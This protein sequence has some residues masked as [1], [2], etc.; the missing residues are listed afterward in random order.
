MSYDAILKLADFYE[1][2]ALVSYGKVWEWVDG[3]PIYSNR[4]Y[5]RA[6]LSQISYDLSSYNKLPFFPKVIIP[7]VPAPIPIS[8]TQKILYYANPLANPKEHVSLRVFEDKNFEKSN[9]DKK[10]IYKLY[11]NEIVYL[12][13]MLTALKQAYVNVSQFKGEQAEHFV[14]AFKP[15]IVAAEKSLRSYI[16]YRQGYM[17]AIK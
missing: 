4:A 2:E 15:L 5:L 7:S 1:T 3:E 8:T 13:N 6:L 10:D 14:K 11:G 9:Y 16:Q 17:S 12:K